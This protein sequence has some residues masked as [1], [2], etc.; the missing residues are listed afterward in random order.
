MKRTTISATTIE[1]VTPTAAKELDE[2]NLEAVTGGI[3][4]VGGILAMPFHTVSAQ[5]AAFQFFLGA[6]K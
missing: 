5:A 2:G 4:I 6:V 3:I 1:N